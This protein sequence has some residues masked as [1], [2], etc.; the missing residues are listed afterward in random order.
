MSFQ[1]QSLLPSSSW[2][3]H[4]NISF[5]SDGKTAQ[6]IYPSVNLNYIQAENCINNITCILLQSLGT[7]DV[8]I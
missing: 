2:T 7:K 1:I 8:I 6:L 3:Y 4:L 5:V